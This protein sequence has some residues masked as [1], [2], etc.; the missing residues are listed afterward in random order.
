MCMPYNEVNYHY[1]F[2]F[3]ISSDSV[4]AGQKFNVI[5]SNYWKKFEG[6]VGLCINNEL[7]VISNEKKL[8]KAYTD[9]VIKI[10][11]IIIQ[12]NEAFRAVHGRIPSPLLEVEN[13]DF[14]DNFIEKEGFKKP[15]SYYE[16]LMEHIEQP[17]GCS[18]EVLYETTK[19]DLIDCTNLWYLSSQIYSKAPYIEDVGFFRI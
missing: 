13:R 9:I 18:D 10:A 3:K 5:I 14:L 8:S 11:D 12:S 6:Y 1:A 19:K 17:D 15:L 4:P 7:L 16:Q 2:E